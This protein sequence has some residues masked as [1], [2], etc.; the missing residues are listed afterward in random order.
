MIRV[1]EPYARSILNHWWVFIARGVLAILFGALAISWP[2]ITVLVLVSLFA[3]FALL[4]G[5]T[6][7]VS[8]IR[9]RHW[10]WP[11]IAGLLSI[12]IGVMAIV[13]P[14]R[15]G[16]ALVILIGVWAVVRGTSD[17]A[18]AVALRRAITQEWVLVLSGVLSVLFGALL[19]LWPGAGALAIIGLIA[20]FSIF[21]GILLIAAG[22]RQYGMRSKK[23]GG[24][25]V[26]LHKGLR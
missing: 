7:T 25:P 10:G 13:W 17:L 5:I 14:A 12:V 24:V 26:V 15:T 6:S 16:T 21:L 11:F 4:D 9:N 8:A 3:A 1:R 20:G 18:A 2:R 22:I 23:N 19:I